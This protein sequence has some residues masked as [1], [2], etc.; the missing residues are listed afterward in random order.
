VDVGGGWPIFAL[1]PT[2]LAVHPIEDGH[3]PEL[4]LVCEDVEKTVAELRT[5]GVEVLRR[6]RATKKPARSGK[7]RNRGS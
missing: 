6:A 5:K 4:Y 1:P 7:K 2:E 3:A